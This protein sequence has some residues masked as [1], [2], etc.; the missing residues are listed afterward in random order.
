MPLFLQIICGLHI[1]Q[2]K[3]DVFNDEKED[4]PDE[5]FLIS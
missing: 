1:L 3:N 5:R 4:I 2:D